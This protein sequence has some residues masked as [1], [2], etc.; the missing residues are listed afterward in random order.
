MSDELQ[1][2]RNE[3]REK[4]SNQRKVVS[5]VNE[6]YP[7][8]KEELFGLSKNAIE[9]WKTVNSLGDEEMGRLF[10]LSVVFTKN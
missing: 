7:D 3:Y 2:P 10:K 4:V 6:K 8:V 1:Q 9:R 5:S